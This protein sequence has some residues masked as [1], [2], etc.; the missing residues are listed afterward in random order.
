MAIDR[1]YCVECD[2]WII[3]VEGV[4]TLEDGGYLWC[5][6]HAVVRYFD[7]EPIVVEWTPGKLQ[8]NGPF[9]GDKKTIDANRDLRKKVKT[10]K[11]RVSFL[12]GLVRSVSTPT[13]S[14]FMLSLIKDWDTQ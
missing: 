6:R 13:P 12:K 4:T 5:V 8:Q 2:E 1:L 9:R 10:L 14:K 3:P 7:G 11:K